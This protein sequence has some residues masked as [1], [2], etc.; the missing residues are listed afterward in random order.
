MSDQ[1]VQKPQTPP[2]NYLVW[3]ILT[4][5]LCC[6]PFGIVSIVFASQVNAK[7]AAG[8]YDGANKSSKNAKTWAWVSFA[9][10]AAGII[11]YAIAIFALGVTAFWANGLNS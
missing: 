4:T 11:I 7:Y 10:G 5:I 8:D 2:P 9:V 1:Q 6:L 3:A